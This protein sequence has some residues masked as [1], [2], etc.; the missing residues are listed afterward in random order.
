MECPSLKTQ[1][2]SIA[3]SAFKG[4]VDGRLLGLVLFLSATPGKSPVTNA[5]QEKHVTLQRSLLS[6]ALFKNFMSKGPRLQTFI[7][8]AIAQFSR[9]LNM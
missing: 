9:T 8:K 4:R 6:C 5:Q 1:R 3:V 2:S 7:S